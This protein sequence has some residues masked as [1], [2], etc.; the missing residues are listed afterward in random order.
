M[1]QSL[2]GSWIVVRRSLGLVG[3]LFVLALALAFTG[4]SVVATVSQILV[5]VLGIWLCVRWLK[6]LTRKA[7]WR[8]RNRLLVTYLFIAVVPVSLI[9]ILSGLGVY[10]TASQI[11]VHLMSSELD[12]RIELL[13]ATA[14]RLTLLK[15]E[16]RK[17]AVEHMLDMM[18]K[19]RFQGL[20]VVVRDGANVIKYPE[21][22]A[23]APPPAGWK[24]VAGL[25][26]HNGEFYGWCHRTTDTGDIT[27]SAPFSS[28][29]LADL[30]PELG[31]A[32]IFLVDAEGPPVADNK[33]K[34]LSFSLG[35]RSKDARKDALPTRPLKAAAYRLD[36]P[37]QWISSMPLFVWDK[38]G[39]GGIEPS[40]EYRALFTVRSR[41]S[42][43]FEVLFS[44]KSSDDIGAILPL[45]LLGVAI[46]F[47]LVE[48][49]ALVIGVSM[50][51]T[52]TE[53]VH[54][55]YEGTQRV[56]QGD[57]T[58]RIEVQGKDQLADLG[59]SFNRMTENIEQLLSISK[60]KERLQSELE[61]AREVQSQLY[62]KAAPDVKGLR[63]RALCKPARMVSGDYYD[64]DMVGDSLLAIALGDVAGKGISAALLMATLQ[65][66]VRTRLSF[67][68]D[69]AIFNDCEPTLSTA[70][71]VSNLNNQLYKTTSPE[72]YATFFLGVFDTGTARFHY[73]NAGH[74]PPMLFRKG[75][76]TNL[77]IDGTVVGAFPF[78]DYGESHVYLEPDDLL[79]CYTDGITEPENAYGEM[80]GDER[81]VETVQRNLNKTE[82][83]ILDAVVEAVLAWT[84]A[85]ELQDDMTLVIA[86]CKAD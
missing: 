42:M 59:Y 22:E 43:I 41:P 16:E 26:H 82:D 54:R 71:L 20:Q 49:V 67:S 68:R 31:V 70:V 85:G 35:S 84:G 52:I 44:R 6:F 79:L 64:Y 55:L 10:A 21:D 17:Y 13:T 65:S 19:D 32:D 53:A 3:I 37:V 18:Y 66:S 11:A 78:A 61:I 39:T 38:P 73:T 36:L 4:I 27:V 74:L 51:R 9:I 14:E 46:L 8:L 75:K 25:V 60:E 2:M 24:D 69:A 57:F 56:M 72:K 33:R 76:V 86:R 58:H 15:P 28:S 50:T 62:P 83:Q 40:G 48:L 23:I 5:V 77:E 1:T 12:R 63:V 45:I 30:V 34:G 80:F 29:Y 7:I 81:L 47:L